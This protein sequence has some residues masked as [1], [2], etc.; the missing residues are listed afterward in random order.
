MLSPVYI[1]AQGLY[2][3]RR[4]SVISDSFP[5]LSTMMQTQQIVEYHF[6]MS[7]SGLKTKK[8]R[9]EVRVNRKSQSS[10]FQRPWRL[11]YS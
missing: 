1:Y 9:T 3:S 2:L 6:E 10:V 7:S 8:A 4:K 11:Q 5:D